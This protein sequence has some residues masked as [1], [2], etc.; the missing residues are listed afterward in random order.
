MRDDTNLTSGERRIGLDAV[1]QRG[2]A[3]GG[4][5]QPLERDDGGTLARDDIKRPQRIR[6]RKYLRAAE[7]FSF[8]ERGQVFGGSDQDRS[9]H[10]LSV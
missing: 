6:V 7:V 10:S 8:L 5:E 9:R 1:D 3:R 4:R 2:A